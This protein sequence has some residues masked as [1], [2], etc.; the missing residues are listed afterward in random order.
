MEGDK[1]ALFT[2]FIQYSCCFFA[3]DIA[4]HHVWTCIIAF[5]KEW[6]AKYGKHERC[7]RIGW[8]NYC[9]THFVGQVVMF[10][11]HIKAYCRSGVSV[12]INNVE[13]EA[14]FKVQGLIFCNCNAKIFALMVI[15][16]IIIHSNNENIKTHVSWS[17]KLTAPIVCC[18]W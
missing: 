16:N 9:L 6:E 7:N 3:T 12:F 11:N 10:K 14:N 13:W 4:I 18:C 17:I 15:R 1:F 2:L 5:W 8:W